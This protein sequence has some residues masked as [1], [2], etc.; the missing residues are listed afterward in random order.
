ML[1]VTRYLI[2]L[3]ILCDSGIGDLD[4]FGTLPDKLKISDKEV[5]KLRKSVEKTKISKL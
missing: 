5:E 1:Q 2:S 4:D 3:D